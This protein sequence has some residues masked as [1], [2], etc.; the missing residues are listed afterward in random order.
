LDFPRV[1]LVG[2]IAADTSLYLPDF[3]AAEKTFQL[4]TQV[5]GRAGR[6]ELKG[7]VVI[8]TYTPEHYSIVHA[9][10]HDYGAFFREEMVQRKRTGYPPYYRLVLITFAHEEVPVVIRA[11]AT[12]ADYLRPRL[13][14]GTQLL[15]PVASPIA[16]IKDRFRFQIMLKYRDEPQ[17]VDLLAQAAAVFEDW[18]K[19]HKALMTIDVD[20]NMLL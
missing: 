3:R 13:A 11:A 12:V 9:T 17:L 15:G 16:R 10:R 4:L 7:D 1:T 2:V 19:Q 5:G 20:P 8:Q 14:A 6:H 18:N